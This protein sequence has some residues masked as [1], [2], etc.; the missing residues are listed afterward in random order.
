[1]SITETIRGIK[2]NTENPCA[3]NRA[4]D[5]RNHVTDKIINAAFLVD[6]HGKGYCRINMAAGNIADGIRHCNNH[7]AEGHGSGKIG[8]NIVCGAVYRDRRAAS[9]NDK[10]AR[11]DKLSDIRFEILCFHSYNS[12]LL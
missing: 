4:E 7:K 3:G 9:E 11:A 5:L 2:E 1:M 12:F 8:G 6:Q 10:H